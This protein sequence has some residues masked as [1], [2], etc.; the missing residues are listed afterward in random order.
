[1]RICA[2]C[3]A[4]FGERVGK[5]RPFTRCQKCRTQPRHRSQAREVRE[6]TCNDCGERIAATRAPDTKLLRGGTRC[7]VCHAK[8]TRERQYRWREANPD[9]W[10]ANQDRYNAKRLADPGHRRRKREAQIQRTY[11]LSVEE[12]DVLLAA[13]DGVCAICRRPPRGRPNG[14]ARPDHVPSLH[15]DHCHGSGRVRGLL[16]GNCN[17][18]IGLAGEDPAVLAAAIAYLQEG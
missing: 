4:E 18:M 15:V 3:G 2:D 10:K 16:C 17:T 8:A 13:Q 11:G 14:N 7:D 5:G 6:S 12:L 9:K 1:M